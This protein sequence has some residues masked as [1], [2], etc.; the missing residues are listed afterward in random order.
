MRKL[1]LDELNR[2]S[3]EEFR[4]A[5][6]A[7]VCVVLDSIRSMHNVGSV[8]RSADAFGIEKVWLCGYSPRPPHRDIRKVAIG[9][10][11]SMDWEYEREITQVLQRLKADGWKLIAVEQTDSSLPLQEFK[12]E[13][14]DKIALIFGNEVKGV[15]DAALELCDLAIEI[16]QFGTKHSLNISVAAGIVLYHTVLIGK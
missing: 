16:P 7:A 14:G 8:F 10:E 13:K 3:P 12:S 9:A 5:P 6:R 15:A 11:D 4:T 1:K 2:L